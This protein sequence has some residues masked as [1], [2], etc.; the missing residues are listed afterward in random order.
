MLKIV[1][2]VLEKKGILVPFEFKAPK[3]I[4]LYIGYSHVI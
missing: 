2:L 4:K 1:F 3:S